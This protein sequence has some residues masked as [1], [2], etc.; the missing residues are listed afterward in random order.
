[1]EAFWTAVVPGMKSMPWV[2]ATI[3]LP[4]STC[5]WNMPPWWS[6]ESKSFEA[7]TI[8]VPLRQT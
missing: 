2:L 6:V 5:W 7:S 3:A 1:M 4:G 8:A